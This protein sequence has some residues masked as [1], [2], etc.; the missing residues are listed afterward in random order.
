MDSSAQ[1][2]ME[3]SHP[4]ICTGHGAREEGQESH[5]VR[6]GRVA[7]M[8]EPGHALCTSMTRH[9]RRDETANRTE[10]PEGQEHSGHCWVHQHEHRAWA[11]GRGTGGQAQ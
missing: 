10:G 6:W 8:G 7:C 11:L 4:A 3:L 1:T 5:D 9:R 2:A